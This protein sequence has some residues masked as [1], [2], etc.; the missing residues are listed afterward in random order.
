MKSVLRQEIYQ[1]YNLLPRTFFLE[2][3]NM[4]GSSKQMKKLTDAQY[5][6]EHSKHH[7]SAMKALQKLGVD[8]DKSHTYVKKY[9]D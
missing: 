5:Y 2:Y 4:Y 6:K 8:R 7:T 9:V 1:F 3:N